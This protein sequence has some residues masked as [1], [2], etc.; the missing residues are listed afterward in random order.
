VLVC[1]QARLNVATILVVDDRA[2]NRQFLTTL[3]GYDGHRVLEAA[4]GAQALEIARA[5]RPDLT[6]SDILMPGMDGH[7]LARALRREPA[8]AQMRLILMSAVYLEDE[9]RRIALACGA[10]HLLAKPAEPE[11]VRALVRSVLEAPPPPPPQAEGFNDEYVRLM[12]EKLY[13]KVRELEELNEELEKRVAERT[14]QLE[15]ANHDLEAFSY[16]ISHD[17]RAPLRAID[18][19][20]HLLEDGLSDGLSAENARSLKF[21]RDGAQRMNALITDL[22]EFSRLGR[23]ALRKQAVAPDDIV[24]R[25]AGD[26]RNEHNGRRIEL[27]VE[28]MPLCQAD[29]GLLAQV[30]ANLLGNAFKYTR[31]RDPAT[32]TVGCRSAN[33]ENVYYV[34]DNG[35]GFD[36]RY[37]DKL[38]NVF[39]RLHSNSEFEGTGVGL[40]IARRIVERHGG[41]IWA[42]GETGKG[43]KFEFTL[44]VT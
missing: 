39:R 23:K 8:L 41:R 12:N 33:G 9:A 36:S 17:L 19:F 38:F 22:L 15:A 11:A 42:Q 3:L 1:G 10:S 44:G 2:S 5:E 32:I 31:G 4:N 7:T 27:H 25:C 16:S 40:A 21:V 14:A 26:L 35:A 34:E 6:I 30:Y 18:G 28:D 20:S 43:A 29:A 37:T 13:Q 24:R